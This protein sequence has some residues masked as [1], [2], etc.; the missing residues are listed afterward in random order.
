MSILRWPRTTYLFSVV[1][2][3]ATLYVR[4]LSSVSGLADVASL[5]PLHVGT[6]PERRPPREV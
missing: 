4:E 1:L 3:A 6:T 5:K 2:L